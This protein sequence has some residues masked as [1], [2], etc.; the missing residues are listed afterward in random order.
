MSILLYFGSYMA[1]SCPAL[2]GFRVYY[3]HPSREVPPAVGRGFHVPDWPPPASARSVQKGALHCTGFT[4]RNIFVIAATTSLHLPVVLAK[5]NAQHFQATR[6]V[7][8]I[9]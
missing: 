7:L 4:S 3:P 6:A 5:S 1:Q 2:L 9:I 8:G